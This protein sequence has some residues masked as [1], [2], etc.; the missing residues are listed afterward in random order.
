M[1]IIPRRRVAAAAPVQNG[2]AV[3]LDP[4]NTASYPGS[5]TTLTDIT[6]GNNGTLLAGATYSAANGGITVLGVNGYISLA[7]MS[8]HLRGVSAFSVSIFTSYTPSGGLQAIWSFG[9]ANNFSNDILLYQQSGDL[10]F[11]VGNGTDGGFSYARSNSGWVNLTAVY[12]GSLAAADR[13]KIYANTTQLSGSQTFTPPTTSS[14]S[15]ANVSSNIGRY[16]TE[17]AQSTRFNA[18]IGPF[19]L[20]NRAI[21]AAENSSNFEVFRA[22]YGL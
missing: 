6:G 9:D 15:T 20:Y 8:T 5:G 12:D 19:L 3:Y 10:V 7:S 14:G 22:R 11:Q 1:L 21:T 2:L 16:S 13:L 18:S 4:G 17:T